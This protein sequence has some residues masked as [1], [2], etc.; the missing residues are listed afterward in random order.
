M[1]VEVFEKFFSM[2]GVIAGLGALLLVA[3]RFLRHRLVPAANA[4]ELF[5]AYRLPVAALVATVA[6]LGSLYFSEVAHFKPCRFCWIQRGF[7]Y[8]LAVALIVATIRKADHWRRFLIPW[9]AV[10]LSVSTYHYLLEWFPEKLETNVCDVKVPCSAFPFR[11]W[12]FSTIALM[13]GC[14]FLFVISVLSLPLESR[15][16]S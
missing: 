7:M 3:A 8:P 6:M 11:L 1:D 16:A 15:R 4:V 5:G 13:A 2:L 9:A 12:S 14:G 10:G